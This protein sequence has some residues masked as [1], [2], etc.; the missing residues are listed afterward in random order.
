MYFSNKNT[1]KFVLYKEFSIFIE[2]FYDYICLIQLFNLI[3][4][5]TIKQSINN[6]SMK[7]QFTWDIQETPVTVNGSVCKDYKALVRSD[8]GKM[9][10]IVSDTYKPITN[11]TFFETI[12]EIANISGLSY[13][14]HE[15]LFGGNRILA[16][17]KSPE[18]KLINGYETENFLMFGTAHDGTSA[19]MVGT[20]NRMIRCNNQFTHLHKNKIFK[21]SHTKTSAEKVGRLAQ[22]YL[23]YQQIES[24]MYQQIERFADL[25]VDSKLIKSFI[26]ELTNEGKAQKLTAYT[27]KVQSDLHTAINRECS[28]LGQNLF[29][30]FNGI[31]Y[32]TTHY[33]N[34]HRG[35]EP[36]FGNA[37]GKMTAINKKALELCFELQKNAPK[38]YSLQ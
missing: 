21:I 33:A 24:T 1:K 17:L 6:L 19:L 4:H 8:N 27:Q 15:E 34:N 31:T 13:Q 2:I 22:S 5:H 23:R 9:L 36:V 25:K 26:S 38:S 12:Q 16:W 35:S 30:L 7:S 11:A 29:G 37:H 32:Y 28:E 20:T 18:K 14:G 10:S 3:L